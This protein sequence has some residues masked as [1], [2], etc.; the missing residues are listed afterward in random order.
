MPMK[1]ILYFESIGEVNTDETL[2]ISKKRA[3]DLGI[4][5]V[6]V[7]STRGN[8]AVKVL[9]TF[10]GFKIVVVPHVTGLRKP[11]MQELTAENMEKIE[12]MDGKV[13]IAAHTFGGVDAAISSK[14]NT[15]YPAGIIAQT[16]RMFGEGMKVVVEIT[17]MAADAG[18]IP[19]DK[20]VLVI[21]GTGKGADTAV[22]VKPANS[23]RFFD[24]AI[25][26][27]IA[28]PSSL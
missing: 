17:A 4:K 19:E 18:A 9:E 7:A 23:R 25:K 12:K 11:G 20:D 1:E 16:L 3:E 6:V 22:V 5:D 14:W 21:A 28:K 13:V 27:I 2:K 8:T 10:K 24:I 26:E 15:M